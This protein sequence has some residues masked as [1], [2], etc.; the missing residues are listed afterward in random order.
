[1]SV[2]RNTAGGNSPALILQFASYIKGLLRLRGDHPR[3]IF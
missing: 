1:M 3:L 2:N